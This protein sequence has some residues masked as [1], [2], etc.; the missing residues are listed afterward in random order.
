LKSF[1][2]KILN[3]LYS[4]FLFLYWRPFWKF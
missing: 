1:H 4:L 2:F 3:N